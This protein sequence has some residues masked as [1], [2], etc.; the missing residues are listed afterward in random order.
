ME[1]RARLRAARAFLIDLDGTVY[2]DEALVP[3]ALELVRILE[4]R[5]PVRFLTNNSSRRGADYQDR[6]GR[7]GIAVARPQIVTSGDATIAYLL[8]ATTLRRPYLVGTAALAA[9]F[10]AAGMDPDPSEPDCVVI[11]YDTSLSYAKLERATTLLFAGLPY[12]ATHPD[13]TCISRHGLRP[14]IA[15][16]VGGLEAVTGRRPEVIGKPN[17]RM[18]ESALAPLGIPCADAVLIGDQL[19]TDMALA[20]AA[21]LLD[22]LVLSGETSMAKLAAWPRR[23]SLIAANAAEVAGWFA[24]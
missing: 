18:A 4:A 16:I 3:G 9:D 23:P 12:F 2:V 22:L 24:E 13:R 8:D 19:D 5:G 6:L 11:G 21:G 1:P 10:H 20:Q 15:V 17:P 14:D 7:L